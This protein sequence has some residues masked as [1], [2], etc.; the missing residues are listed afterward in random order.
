VAY[1][2]I[3]SPN[4]KYLA[5]TDVLI[6][7]MSDINYEFLLFDRPII[8]LAN[9]WLRK[10]FPD[11]GIKTDLNNLEFAIERSIANPKEFSEKRR[12]WLNKTM[13]KPDSNSSS[14]VIDAILK[15]S[16]ISNPFIILIHGNNEVLKTHLDS[17]YRVIKEKNI[18]VDYIDFF[19]S[20]LYSNESNLICISA[21]NSL[22]KDILY[23]YRVH[24]D[25]GVKGLGTTD[26]NGLIKQYKNV[27]YFP[28]VDLHVTEGE[29]SYK[30]TKIILGPYSDR[31]IMVGYPKSDTLLDLGKK[32]V[33]ISVCKELGFNPEKI[34]VTYA[35]AGKYSY[36]FKQGASLT[37]KVIEKMYSIGNKSEYNILI[38]LKY[39]KRSFFV[40]ISNKLKKV[41]LG[42]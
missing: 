6:G 35:P 18:E 29:V 1:K 3:G 24:I 9:K 25:H 7:D 20:D 39:P 42:R 30:K 26:L 31:V 11:I 32:K 12:Y 38:K 27:N 19:N 41:C 33:K 34:L 16:K 15:Y 13:Y 5:A 10:N 2:I 28:M 14:R 36:P 40:R 22:L 37:N 8:L 17:L 23:G 4:P 21:S